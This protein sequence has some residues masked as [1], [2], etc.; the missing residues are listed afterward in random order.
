MCV[1]Y[2]IFTHSKTDVK[3]KYITLG[4][5]DLS[6]NSETWRKKYPMKTIV[7]NKDYL[8]LIEFEGVDFSFNPKL[9]PICLPETNSTDGTLIVLG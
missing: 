4:V 2:F 1:Q 9:K 5:Y 6:S 8:A 3:N 7:V